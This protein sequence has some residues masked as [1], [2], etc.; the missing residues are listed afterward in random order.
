MTQISLSNDLIEITAEINSFKQVAGQAVFEIGKRLKHVKENDL[1]HGQ[2][3]AWLSSVDIVPRT[4]RAMIQAYEQ[5]GN[6]QTSTVLETGK[7]FE[8]LSLPET[9]DR[10]EF[11]EQPHIIP[12]T[13]EEKKV[14]EMTVRELREVKKSLQAAE[15][16][17]EKLQHAASHYEKLWH[18]AKDKPPQVI[19]KSVEIVPEQ[20]KRQLEDLKFENQNLKAGYQETQQELQNYKVRDT[21]EFDEIEAQKQRRKLQHEAELNALQIRVKIN[22][23]LEETAI[24][25]FMEGALAAVDPI[26]KKKIHE[27]LDMLDKFT[28]QIK[29]SLN[30]RIIGG[31]INE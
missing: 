26:S 16:E 5:F 27:S 2:W 20:I 13:G 11:I 23:F 3:E 15:K 17:R 31:V 4:A 29:A 1:V 7:I 25:A 14:D 28:N 22:K 12:S 9:I 18:Q 19:T 30:G 10:K 24:T 6:R 8:M 21:V